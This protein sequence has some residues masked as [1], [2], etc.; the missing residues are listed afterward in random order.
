MLPSEQPPVSGMREICTHGLNGRFD[1]N[2]SFI[3]DWSKDLPM[4]RDFAIP[5]LRASCTRC[6]SSWRGRGAMSVVMPLAL[7][8]SPARRNGRLNPD[9]D[10]RADCR[11]DDSQQQERNSGTRL[12]GHRQVAIVGRAGRV[13]GRRIGRSRRCRSSAM[14]ASPAAPMAARKASTSSGWTPSA[15][16]VSARWA[17][18]S[19][20]RAAR[21]RRHRLGQHRHGQQH[22][23]PEPPATSLGD[24]AHERTSLNR[25]HRRASSSG[26]RCGTRRRRGL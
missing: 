15:G 11:D 2:T 9:R 4:N 20:C 10:R 7:R 22:R 18:R 1:F 14:P 24:L 21:R 5:E 12:L 3:K 17:V 26:R 13:R 16:I 25:H 6:V 23:V 8:S 19:P